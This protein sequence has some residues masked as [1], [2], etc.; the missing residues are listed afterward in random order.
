MP[1]QPGQ[2]GNPAGRPRGARNRTTVLVESLIESD[3]EAFARQFVA[4]AKAGNARALALL[5]GVILP[6]RKGAP[7]EID[8]PALKQASD[9]PV[10]IAAIL[11]A[12]CAGELTPEEGTSLTR[13]VQAFLRVEQMAEKLGRKRE[14]AAHGAAAQMREAAEPHVGREGEGKGKG[15]GE[16]ASGDAAVVEG[17]APGQA[18]KP[19]APFAAAAGLAAADRLSGRSLPRLRRETLNTAS[20]AAHSGSGRARIVF[21]LLI[22]RVAPADCEKTR[23]A[24]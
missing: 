12:V 18:A 9:A 7:V 20:V 16:A 15:K 14:R 19:N 5:M 13:M 24:A 11:A 6:K 17:D 4:Q 23:A 21:P 2:S 8:L 22:P 10:A 3:A 1:F